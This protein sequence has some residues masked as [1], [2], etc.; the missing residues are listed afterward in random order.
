MQTL[1]WIAFTGLWDTAMPAKRVETNLE[2]PN[3]TLR[4][5]IASHQLVLVLVCWSG[6]IAA[7]ADTADLTRTARTHVS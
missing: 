6:G 2:S 4:A 3:T 1:N 5:A 7:S